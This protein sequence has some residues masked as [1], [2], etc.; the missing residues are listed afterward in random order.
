MGFTFVHLTRHLWRA[1]AR[2]C[3][4]RLHC[5]GKMG[6]NMI[7][8]LFSLRSY[9]IAFFISCIPII[10]IGAATTVMH[11]HLIVVFL[12]NPIFFVTLWFIWAMSYFQEQHILVRICSKPYASTIEKSLRISRLTSRSNIRY[13]SNDNTVQVA[14]GAFCVQTESPF[15]WTPWLE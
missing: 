5:S 12:L 8:S 1:C 6:D 14:K 15:I 4:C 9:F 13:N 10:T 11:M 3:E 2:H 7:S